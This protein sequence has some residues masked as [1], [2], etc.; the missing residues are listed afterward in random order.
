M[1]EKNVR[2]TQPDAESRIIIRHQNL[3]PRIGNPETIINSYIEQNQYPTTSSFRK[4]KQND[5]SLYRNAF[6]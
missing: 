4:T 1:K 2:G 5:E 3:L 6:R